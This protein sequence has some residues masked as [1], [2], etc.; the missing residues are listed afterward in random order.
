M[1]DARATAGPA[2]FM[3]IRNARTESGF[4]RSSRRAVA[5]KKARGSKRPAMA[6][7]ELK[8]A[9]AREEALRREKR[10]LLQRQNLLTQEFEHRLVNS[11]QMI[12][13][14][15]SLQG[16]AATTPEVTAQLKIAADRVAAF[17]RVHRQLHHL[18]R[19]KSV[20]L[21]QYLQGLC[22][23]L[24]GLLFQ[25][26]A[27]RAVVVTG[28]EVKLPTALGIP[29]GFVVN[30]LITNSAKYAQGDITVSVETSATALSLSVADEGPGLPTGFDPAKSKGLGM[31]IVQAL[32][33]QNGGV[34]Q[35][36]HGH[37]GRGARTTVVFAPPPRA[38]PRKMESTCDI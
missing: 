30:E 8:A 4:Q 18:D 19:Q 29:L 1:F 9:L 32:V 27:G 24:A 35:F 15:L 31:K 28:A 36:A 7:A 23:D 21:K 3:R 2:G 14:L 38:G 11:L 10:A 13:S 6:P 17:G 34:L 33:R 12:V 5:R 22:D 20:E 16:R 37:G 26:G 25:D